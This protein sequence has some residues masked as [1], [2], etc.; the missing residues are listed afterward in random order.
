MSVEVLGVDVR[1]ADE[2]G[3]DPSLKFLVCG[4]KGKLTVYEKRPID[5]AAIMVSS[6]QAA[7]VGATRSPR[8]RPGWHVYWAE[9]D[10]FAT[11]FTW[12]GEPDDGFGRWR[13]DV[14]LSDG[15]VEH[16]IGGWHTGPS[17]AVEAGFPETLDIAVV[18]QEGVEQHE[19]RC[20][21]LG[22]DP[23]PWTRTGGLGMFITVERARIEI[24]K[25]RPDLEWAESRFGFGPVVKWRG[26]PSKA[27]F[28]AVDDVRRKAIRDG[29]KA[30][31]G[32]GYGRDNWWYKATD[33]EKA[34]MDQRPY[35]ALGAVMAEA[36]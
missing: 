24:A 4:L 32:D 20:R 33:A 26:Q 21:E 3:N 5:G 27:E 8:K 30:R 28:Q 36:A 22:R 7:I 19:A 31:Y 13:R 18:D 10:G 15:T 17:V 11:F 12:G 23:N 25:H 16:V 6:E 35:S 9:L 1:W 29:L 34:E 2:Y 14:H